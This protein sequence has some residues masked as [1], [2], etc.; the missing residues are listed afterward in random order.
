M[1]VHS[2]HATNTSAHILARVDS[3]KQATVTSWDAM[4]V[5]RRAPNTL[6]VRHVRYV[7]TML[8]K[9]GNYQEIIFLLK[10]SIRILYLHDHDPPTHHHT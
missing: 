9:K 8:R 3:I 2:R 5:I 10:L 4:S 6:A 1:L 7:Q